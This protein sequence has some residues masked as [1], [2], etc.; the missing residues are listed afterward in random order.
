MTRAPG[1]HRK[2]EMH[3]RSQS[4]DMLRNKTKLL[5]Y[6]KIV[7]LSGKSTKAS[8]LLLSQYETVSQRIDPGKN[9]DRHW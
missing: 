9:S 3:E 6:K 8:S 4:Q 1:L 7:S 2:R 5:N